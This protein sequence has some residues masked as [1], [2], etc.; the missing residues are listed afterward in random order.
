[1]GGLF[2][3]WGLNPLPKNFALN[4]QLSTVNCQLLTTSRAIVRNSVRIKNLKTE[5]RTIKPILYWSID[6]TRSNILRI[7]DKKTVYFKIS[8]LAARYLERN[9]IFSFPK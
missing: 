6:R 9:Q 2:L 4:C 5:V 3:G 1:L 8:G 7:L